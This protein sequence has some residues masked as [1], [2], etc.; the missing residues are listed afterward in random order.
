MLDGS[1]TP[2][3]QVQMLTEMVLNHQQSNSSIDA[4]KAV[5]RK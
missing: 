3:I 2:K 5:L 4:F 1:S